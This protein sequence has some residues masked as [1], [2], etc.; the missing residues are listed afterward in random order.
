M[1]TTIPDRLILRGLTRSRKMQQDHHLMGNVHRACCRDFGIDYYGIW[2]HKFQV[3]DES[4][5]DTFFLLLPVCCNLSS[6]S[7]QV[8]ST[9]VKHC[10]YFGNISDASLGINSFP[11]PCSCCSPHSKSFSSRGADREFDSK[12]LLSLLLTSYGQI[13]CLLS[14]WKSRHRSMGKGFQGACHFWNKEQS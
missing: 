14:L 11:D 6:L 10:P 9:I 12:D 7:S 2:V 5:E 13:S 8:N 1:D 3:P 4:A